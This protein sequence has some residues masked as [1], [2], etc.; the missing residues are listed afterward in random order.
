MFLLLT[1][2][3]EFCTL[4]NLYIL[5]YDIVYIHVHIIGETVKTGSRG[6]V[7]AFPYIPEDSTGPTRTDKQ[8]FHTVVFSHYNHGRV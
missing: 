3:L 8:T 5:V 4:S 2:R 6:R 1:K 7:H